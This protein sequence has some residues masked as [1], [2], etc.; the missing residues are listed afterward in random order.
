[1]KRRVSWNHKNAVW[2]TL[3]VVSFVVSVGLFRSSEVHIA[4]VFINVTS[5]RCVNENDRPFIHLVARLG[6]GLQ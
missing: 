1:M 2:P 3:F 6:G 5:L 4:S